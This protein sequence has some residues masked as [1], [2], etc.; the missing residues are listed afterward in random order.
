LEPRLALLLEVVRQFFFG[1]CIPPMSIPLAVPQFVVDSD[2]DALFGRG[3]RIEHEGWWIRMRPP[4]ADPLEQRVDRRWVNRV[5]IARYSGCAYR[6]IVNVVATADT[7]AGASPLKFTPGPPAVAVAV[8]IENESTRWCLRWIPLE[9]TRPR[10][11][12]CSV[13]CS[14]LV[15]EQYGVNL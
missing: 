5:W 14:T 2:K 3:R 9:D 6:D 12:K 7:P 10:R 11:R 4:A 13:V 1:D 15:S 8:G